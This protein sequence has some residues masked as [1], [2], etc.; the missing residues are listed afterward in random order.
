MK[1][2]TPFYLGDIVEMKKSHPCG[3]TRWEVVRLGMDIRAKCLGCGRTVLLSR[4]KFERAVRRILESP[5]GD[6]IKEDQR[7]S[8]NSGPA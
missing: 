5:V 7:E 6:S 2:M 1:P 3:E 8:G 4:R